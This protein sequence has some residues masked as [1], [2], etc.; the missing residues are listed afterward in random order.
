MK[1]NTAIISLFGQL[2]YHRLGA[3]QKLPG[4]LGGKQ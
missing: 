3:R 2:T 1:A 4:F